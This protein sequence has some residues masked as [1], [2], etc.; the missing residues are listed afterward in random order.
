MNSVTHSVS[1]YEQPLATDEWR[2]V[3]L[4]RNVHPKNVSEAHK[5]YKQMGLRRQQSK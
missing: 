3:L 1:E 4:F 2:I 5:I